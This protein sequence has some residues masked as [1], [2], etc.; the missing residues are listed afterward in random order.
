MNDGIMNTWNVMLHEPYEGGVLLFSC[1]KQSTA[2]YLRDWCEAE[3]EERQRTIMIQKGWHRF[4]FNSICYSIEES[5][6]IL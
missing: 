4:M 2:E 3:E 6:V 5:E 1:A